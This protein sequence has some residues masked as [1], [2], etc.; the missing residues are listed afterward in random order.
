MIKPHMLVV[1]VLVALVGVVGCGGPTSP[2]DTN[3][4]GTW[5]GTIAST[6]GTDSVGMTIAESSGS[7]SGTWSSIYAS[8][9]NANNG[10]QLTGTKTGAN[11]AMTLNPSVPTNCPYTFNATVTS[12]T[13]LSGTFASFNCTVSLTGQ[14]VLTKQ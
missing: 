11:V 8:A 6:L 14:L 4:S 12:A 1:L 5:T 3:I 2:A 10:G 9:P 13:S 7:L